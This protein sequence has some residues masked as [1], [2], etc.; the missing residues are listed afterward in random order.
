VIAAAL[1]VGALPFGSA[2]AAAPPPHPPT[3]TANGVVTPNSAWE[4]DGDLALFVI[5]DSVH[6]DTITLGYTPSGGIVNYHAWCGVLTYS[7]NG[8]DAEEE[9]HL[10]GDSS[11]FD[12]GYVEFGVDSDF[13]DGD[14][15][16]TEVVAS[17]PGYTA[18]QGH[19][20][21]TIEQ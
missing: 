2:S 21:A 15:L 10:C 4:Y 5:G 12:I 8:T 14:E 6:V 17:D 9:Y 18:P 11:G 19:P 1:V 20:C 13:H 7:V 3:A 16:C